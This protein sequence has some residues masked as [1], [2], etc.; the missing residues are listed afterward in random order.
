MNT[1][2]NSSR[3]PSATIASPGVS[4]LMGGNLVTQRPT[5]AKP[6]LEPI[7]EPQAAAPAGPS[8]ARY[9]N[10]FRSSAFDTTQYRPPVRPGESAGVRAIRE[11]GTSIEDYGR[12][13]SDAA[14][15]AQEAE[16]Q[17]QFAEERAELR[18]AQ[19]LEA[20][21]AREAK[22]RKNVENLMVRAALAAKDDERRGAV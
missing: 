16:R 14:R 9:S 15:Q 19:E 22:E 18:R 5:T 4:S 13:T 12:R 21:A 3:G 7:Y 1:L 10:T 20:R 11:T 8:F 6:A 17:R 2:G